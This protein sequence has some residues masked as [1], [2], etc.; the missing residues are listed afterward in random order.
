[1]Q[2]VVPAAGRGQRFLEAG[3]SDPKPLIKVLGKPI[4][5][6]STDGLKEVADPRFI[7][8][9]LKEHLESNKL[10]ECLRELY[11]N[12]EV[13][14]VDQLTEG[15]AC[16]V[17][18]AKEKLD[19]EQELII[20]NCDNLFY[21]DM[22][23]VK[24]KLG[25]GDKAVIFYFASNSSA[26]SYV[27]ADQAGYAKRIAEKEVISDKATVGC[28]YFTKAK[29]FIE[30]AEYMIKNNIR[31]KGEFYVAPTYNI[32]IEQGANIRVFPV[33]FHFNLGTP[34]EINKFKSLFAA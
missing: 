18:L 33:E 21:I 27:E 30:S 10:D 2:I 3:Y 26:L 1:M 13:I 34:E 24:R 12:C 6:W 7:F 15:A 31:T 8:L 16:T 19:P 25:E 4:I 23:K 28:Y 11:G 22:D 32:L 5:K 14:A 29:Y 17:L 20:V 9:V